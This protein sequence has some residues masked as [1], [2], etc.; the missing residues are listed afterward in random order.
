MIQCKQMPCDLFGCDESAQDQAEH[1]LVLLLIYKKNF[2]FGV[3]KFAEPAGGRPR[4]SADDRSL[5]PP[6]QRQPGRQPGHHLGPR[7][8]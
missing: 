8:Q 6:L 4:P 5:G 3:D 1:G 7:R 2:S